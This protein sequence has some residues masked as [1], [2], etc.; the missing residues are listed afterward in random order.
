MPIAKVHVKAFST[1]CQNRRRFVLA[2]K[3]FKYFRYSKEACFSDLTEQQKSIVV[4]RQLANLVQLLISC[5]SEAKVL[6][7]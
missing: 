6:T 2:E 4:E 5:F 3:A 7:K 1:G